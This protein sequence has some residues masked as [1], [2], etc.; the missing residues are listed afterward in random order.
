MTATQDDLGPTVNM[1]EGDR[2][3]HFEG[4]KCSYKHVSNLNVYRGRAV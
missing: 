3:G 2:I 4:K 1:L